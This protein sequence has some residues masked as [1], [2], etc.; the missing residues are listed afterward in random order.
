MAN[1]NRKSLNSSR[2]FAGP[3]SALFQRRLEEHF[4]VFDGRHHYP[5]M[6]H[7]QNFQ[8]SGHPGFLQLRIEVLA[9]LHRYQSIRIAMDD[10]KRRIVL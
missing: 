6:P 5:L 2:N 4:C 8:R 10:Q 7:V 3:H 1:R 9:L